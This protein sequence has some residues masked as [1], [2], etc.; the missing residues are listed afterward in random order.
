MIIFS[1][2]SRWGAEKYIFHDEIMS[3]TVK[4]DHSSQ[5]AIK[6]LYEFMDRKYNNSQVAYR[7]E[8]EQWTPSSALSLPALKPGQNQIPQMF[9]VSWESQISVWYLTPTRLI[10]LKVLVN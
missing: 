6:P 10:M 7:K 3:T 8:T 9:L 1:I 4:R 2:S 5:S